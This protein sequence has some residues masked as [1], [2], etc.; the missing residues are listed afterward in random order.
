[1]KRVTMSGT[2]EQANSFPLG[3]MFSKY[4]LPIYGKQ[5]AG[6]EKEDP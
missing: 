5:A 6:V 1:M 3:L 4:L 2:S